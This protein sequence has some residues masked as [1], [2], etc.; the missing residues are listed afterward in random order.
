MINSKQKWLQTV[1][2]RLAPPAPVTIGGLILAALLFF[3]FNICNAQAPISGSTIISAPRTGSGFTA[4]LPAI[5]GGNSVCEGST[6][7]L[8]N[9]TTGGNWTSNNTSIA[10]V[11]A[12]T[13]VVTGLAAGTAII[14]YTFGSSYTYVTITVMSAIS[15][16][17]TICVGNVTTMTDSA[18]AGNWTSSNT[19]LATVTPTGVVSGVAAGNVTISYTRAGCSMTKSLTI[20]PN[21]LGAISGTLAVCAGGTTSLS[22]AV[23]GGTW[24][25]GNTA[26]ATIDPTSG[27]ATGVAMGTPTITYAQGGCYKTM[28]LIVNATSPAAI[29]G[30]SAVCT[31]NNATLADVTTGGTWSSSSANATVTTHGVI[32]GVTAGT[33]TISYTKTGCSATYPV[34]VNT[35]GLAAITGTMVACVGGATALADASGAGTWTSSNTGLATVDASGNVTGVATGMPTITYTNGG[36][37]KTAMVTINNVA[38]SAISGTGAVCTAQTSSVSDATLGGVWS[39]SDVTKATVNAY[40]VVTGVAVG[41]PT[42]SYTKLGCSATMPFTVSAT[43]AAI[44]GTMSVCAGLNTTLADATAGGTWTTSNAAVA[45]VSGTGVVTGVAGGTATIYYT[46]GTCSVATLVTVNAPA[47]ITGGNTVCKAPFT[48]LYL[49]EPGTGGSWSSAHTTIATISAGVVTP[50]NPGTDSIVYTQAVTGCKAYLVIT[51]NPGAGAISGNNEVCASGSTI[52]LTDT[53]VTG[54]WS[55]SNPALATVGSTTGFVTGVSA[56]S[57]LITFTNAYGCSMTTNILVDAPLS[58]I[59]GNS[60]VCAGYA[61]DTLTDA[62]PGGMWTASNGN[63][64]V[65][66]SGVIKGII[67]GTTTV[68]YTLGGCSATKPITVNANGVGSITAL[69][70]VCIGSPITL[71]ETTSGGTWTTSSPAVATASTI[72]GTHGLL[73]GLT[74]GTTMVTYTVA[75]GCFKYT[76]STIAVNAG[77]GTISGGYYVCNNATLS[78]S[79]TATGGAWTSSD[80]AKATISSTGVVH[81]VNPGTLTVTYSMPGGC[82]TY[83]PFTVVAQPTTITGS[84]AVGVAPCNIAAGAQVIEAASGGTWSSSNTGIFTVD[85]SGNLT[86]VA[87]GTANAVYT[88]TGGTATCTISKAITVSASNPAVITGANTVC[89][90]DTTQWADATASGTWATSNSFVAN[91]SSGKVNGVT[92]GVAT[93]SYTKNGCYVT[94]TITVNANPLPSITGGPYVCQGGT[95]QLANTVAGGT[96]FKYTFVGDTTNILSIGGTGLVTGI[97]VGNKNIGYADP[98]SGCYILAEMTVNNVAPAAITGTASVCAGSVTTLADLTTGGTWTSDNASVATVNYLGIVTGVAAGTANIN[99]V[100]N[101]C[102]VATPT[103]YT[104]NA[105][106]AAITGTLKVCAGGTTALADATGSGTWSSVTTGK[107]TVDASGVVTGVA[108]NGSSVIKYT[109]G[110]CFASATVTVGVV[111]TAIAGATQMCQGSN[112]TLTDVTDANGIWTSSNLSVI[113]MA[114]FASAGLGYPYGSS[115]SGSIIGN[116][117]GVAT[118]T[119]TTPGCT[120][121]TRTD[122]VNFVAPIGGTF[123]VCTLSTT[124]LT[125]ATLAGSWTSSATGVATVD[126]SG[127]VSGVAAGSATITYTVGS[128]NATQAVYVSNCGRSGNGYTGSSVQGNDE[129]QTYTLYP[130]P[131]NGNITLMQGIEEDAV[132]SVK[133][134]NYVGATVY[135]GSLQF[136]G[137]RSQ[138]DI[139]HVNSGMYLVQLTDSKGATQTFKMVIEK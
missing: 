17:S 50:V 22:D 20:N 23:T 34:T 26:L 60:T 122:T 110:G 134:I 97:S 92:P 4:M 137:G 44:T 130:N 11:G 48:Y 41:T 127:N 103:A 13:G 16:A 125:D 95:I 87:A 30:A 25:S 93:I 135:T 56:G 32:T 55:S 14:S 67:A 65:L 69:Y 54:T 121:V 71:T 136:A 105:T 91:I 84:S 112:I 6:L 81:G 118:V 133:V 83:Q 62:T 75:G 78:L 85:A 15:G 109:V 119:Y 72:D 49:T 28:T 52:T 68:S 29:T 106:P 47:A 53:T 64:I 76:G 1:S 19:A 10:T 104:V 27:V 111:P 120:P 123:S 51:V 102:G 2:P 7:T 45:T 57:V 138:L 115:T 77:A 79:S 39:S 96:W 124:A 116:S 37:Y 35:N 33:A 132:M 126:G 114:V 9:P 89:T 58:P 5:A 128:C 88:I 40:G 74:T 117:A 8:T 129:A 21:G 73:T 59:V 42:I 86:G 12:S 18:V 80:A 98:T 94:K 90:A 108:G 99:Y 61:L 139:T 66:S 113:N 100:V 38:P 46:V 24:T 3:T 131:S 31:G 101:G 36:C 43:P 107:A 63:V 70:S 82:E